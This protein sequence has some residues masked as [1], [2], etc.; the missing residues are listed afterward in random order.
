MV[1][2]GLVAVA[3]VVPTLLQLVVQQPMAAAAAAVLVETPV[4]QVQL[5]PL[6]ISTLL[7]ALLVQLE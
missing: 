6:H 1:Q 4:L 5:V 2:F 7:V 3:V